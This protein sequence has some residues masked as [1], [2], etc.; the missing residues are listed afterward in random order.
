MSSVGVPATRLRPA[1]QAKA[2]YVIALTVGS[3]LAVAGFNVLV[4]EFYKSAAPHSLAVALVP[5]VATTAL[6]LAFLHV[7]SS[8]FTPLLRVALRSSSIGLLAYL[9]VERPDFTLA[10]D[11]YVGDAAYIGLAYYIVLPLAAASVVWPAFNIPVAI[12]IISAGYL[13]TPIS[14]IGSSTL[15]IRYMVDMAVYLTI[16][17]I[18]LQFLARRGQIA[19]TAPHQEVITFIS[20]GLHLGNYF[21]SGVAKAVAGPFPWTWPIENRTENLIPYA[22]DKGTLPF[23]HT[24]WL[25]DYVYSFLGPLVVPMNFAIIGFQLFA[26]VCVLRVSWLKIATTFYDMMHIGIYVLGGLLFWPWI[27]NNFTILIATS[28]L[29][30]GISRPAKAAC[31]LTI[32]LG[33]PLVEL[34]KSARLGWFDVADARQSYFEAVTSHGNVRVPASFFLSHS[35]GVSLGYVDA[36]AHSGHYGHSNWNAARDYG[37]Q[38]TSGSCPAPE[39]HVKGEET[40]EE[41]AQ[42]LDRIGRFIRAH[43][44]KMLDRADQYGPHSYYFRL[45]HHPSNPYMFQPFGELDLKDVQAFNLVLE[46]ACYQLNDGH[47]AKRVVARTVERFDVR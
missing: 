14:G 46:S 44:A 41:R 9:I 45:H 32:L 2:L 4:K 6:A 34:Y 28:R 15:D 25:V 19:D 12:Y 38:L 21:W 30:D 42:R 31:I 20:F 35:Y 11:A 23:G 37:R 18:G 27:W 8:D 24:P 16:F 26:I 40:A 22:I 7:R 43:Y 17:P 36:K 13:I 10:A 33:N 39:A 1:L 3:L 47:I 29:R 5:I